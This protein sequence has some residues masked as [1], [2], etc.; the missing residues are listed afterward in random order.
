MRPNYLNSMQWDQALA[1]ARQACARVFRDGGTPA[2]AYATL[3]LPA[4]SAPDSDWGKAVENI[5]HALYSRP[6]RKAA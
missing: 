6:A 5:A 3:G 1:M 2:D 4:E